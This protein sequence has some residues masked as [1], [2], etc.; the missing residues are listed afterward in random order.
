VRREASKPPE[1]AKR[2]GEGEMRKLIGLLLLSAWALVP[3]VA[4]AAEEG[5]GV[6][7]IFDVLQKE[8]VDPGQPF[9]STPLLRGPNCSF[10]L[11]QLVTVVKSH[12]HRDRDE[13]V[14]LVRG[15]GL[16]TIAGREYQVMP[17]YAYLVPK[18]TIHRFVNLG[19]DPAVVL[20]VFSPAFDGKDR[21][22]VEE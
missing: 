20:S 12:Y 6:V 11:A 14:Y 15:N 1:A 10:N 22:F 4:S 21:I 7:Y 13:V 16:V 19:P 17:G 8:K 3:A 18:G 9:Q 5:G 2:K